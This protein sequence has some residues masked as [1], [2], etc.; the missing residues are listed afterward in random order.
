MSQEEQAARREDNVIWAARG[1]RIRFA[2][3]HRAALGRASELV[4]K[5]SGEVVRVD[6]QSSSVPALERGDKVLSEKVPGLGV[7]VTHRLLN[8]T[9]S[10]AMEQREGRVGIRAE[11]S[12]A[13]TVGD[14]RLALGTERIDLE[15][16]H[17]RFDTRGEYILCGHPLSLNPPESNDKA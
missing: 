11:Q 4:Y 16:Q 5:D 8:E 10:P 6:A 7:V 3:V 13:L 2:T 12:L 1:K 14:S 15:T 17:A 9:E